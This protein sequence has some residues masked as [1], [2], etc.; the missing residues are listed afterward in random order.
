MANACLGY[1]SF[2]M[3]IQWNRL[4]VILIEGLKYFYIQVPDDQPSAGP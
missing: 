4:K 1:H 3:S 2:K